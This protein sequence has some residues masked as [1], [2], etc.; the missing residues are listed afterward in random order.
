MLVW[1][2]CGKRPESM[3]II[4][5]LFIGQSKSQGQVWCIGV[6]N[7]KQPPERGRVYLWITTPSLWY[8]IGKDPE[9]QDHW[10]NLKDGYVFWPQYWVSPT[11]NS[12]PIFAA[13][14]SFWKMQ[15]HDLVLEYHILSL[16]KPFHFNVE[17]SYFLRLSKAHRCHIII[18]LNGDYMCDSKLT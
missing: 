13:S 4:H 1:S 15:E 5:L 2:S 8:H 7:Y 9:T 10:G 12:W 18:W 3:A 14:S 11:P 16:I 17:I 6:E